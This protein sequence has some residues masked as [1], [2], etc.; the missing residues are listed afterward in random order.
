MQSLVGRGGGSRAGSTGARPPAATRGSAARLVLTLAMLVTGG[1]AHGRPRKALP[2]EARAIGLTIKQHFREVN[3]CY[4]AAKQGIPT[5]S[6][7]LHLRFVLGSDGRIRESKV[8][9]STLGSPAMVECV[10][11]E[12]TALLFP[13]R[14]T[15]EPIGFLWKASFEPMD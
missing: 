4:F 2:D 14:A 3:A 10:V 12:I 11:R 8:E 6:G 15:A 1:C 5:L 13:G 9:R 7:D